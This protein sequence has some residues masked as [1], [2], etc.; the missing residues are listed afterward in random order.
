MLGSLVRT[1]RREKTWTQDDLAQ[2]VGVSRVQISRLED[3]L[4]GVSTEVLA[5]L[6]DALGLDHGEVLRAAA[7]TARRR[8]AAQE[9]A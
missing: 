2:L 7:E 6:A 8:R 4:V 5:S 3:D 9:A 1:R